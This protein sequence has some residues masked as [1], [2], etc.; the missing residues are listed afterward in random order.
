MVIC[1]NYDFKKEMIGY[2]LRRNESVTREY[3]RRFAP[4]M[5]SKV[6]WTYTQQ[7]L[8]SQSFQEARKIIMSHDKSRPLFLYLPLMSL[9]SPHVGNAPRRF[10]HLYNSKSTSGFVSSDRMREVLLMTVD[11]ALHKVFEDLKKSGLYKNRCGSSDGKY[12][13]DLMT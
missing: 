8:I 5:Y 3:H 13:P 6:S 11:F 7:N 1:D 4:N 2:D 9:Q 12:D 10:R